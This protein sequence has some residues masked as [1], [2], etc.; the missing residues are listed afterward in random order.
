M[1]NLSCTGALLVL[2]SIVACA[3]LGPTADH[4]PDVAGQSSQALYAAVGLRWPGNSVMVCWENASDP[5]KRDWVRDSVQRTWSEATNFSFLGWGDCTPGQPG[6]HIRVIDVR[7][8][9]AY[10]G[11]ALDGVAA[12]VDLNFDFVQF[13]CTSSIETCTRATAIHEFGHALGFFH[14]QDR[15]DTPPTCT[16]TRNVDPNATAYGAWDAD[17]VMNYCK[18][19]PYPL[20][21]SAGDIF[22][23]QSV[24][25]RKPSGSLYMGGNCIVSF[26]GDG[27]PVFALHCTGQYQDAWTVIPTLP[28]HH[29]DDNLILGGKTGAFGESVQLLAS[30]T[31]GLAFQGPSQTIRLVSTGGRCLAAGSY[32]R[33]P[34]LLLEDCLTTAE[35]AWFYS[36]WTGALQN[37]LGQCMLID[38]AGRYVV[39]GS[40]TSANPPKWSF[41]AGGM[42]DLRTGRCVQPAG[43]SFNAHTPFVIASCDGSIAQQV[44]LDGMLRTPS[45]SCLDVASVAEGTVPTL[46][47]CNNGPT[48]H[49]RWVP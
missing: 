32:L 8:G 37:Q 39:P 16:D 13:G 4:A 9:V 46:K 26:D 38:A 18:S 49:A 30:T 11:K 2:T 35:Q 25:G 24:Y 45:G 41:T 15:A 48:Q 28:I 36:A 40:C 6:I 22:G 43:G 20:A 27:A 21:L 17:S 14:E 12:G 34:T 19:N 42:K 47:G 3:D 33:Q 29:K 23:A 7:S 5:V 31:Q 44:T 10:F 1:K